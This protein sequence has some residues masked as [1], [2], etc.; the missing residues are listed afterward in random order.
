MYLLPRKP[1]TILG[2]AAFGGI[3][4]AVMSTD[5][6]SDL[7]RRSARMLRMGARVARWVATEL[8]GVAD[9][10][11]SQVRDQ[12][13]VNQEWEKVSSARARLGF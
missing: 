5:G 9:A 11:E 3:V 8:D 4:L 6:G 12:S 13:Y 1:G 7:A 10:V 2:V